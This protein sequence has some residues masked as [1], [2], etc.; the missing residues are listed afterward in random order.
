MKKIL[1]TGA[2]TGIGF[3]TAEQ[4]VKQGQHVILAC[5][6]PQKAQ[7]AQ[8]K[9]RALD[10]GQVDLI[11]LDLNS[12]ELIRKAADEIADRYGN[13]D[14]LINNAGLF[15]KTKQ[16]TI[17]GF[18]QQFGVNYLGHFL[19]TQKL[20]PVLQQSPQARIVHLASIAHWAGSIKPNKFRAEG[21][22]NPLFYYGQSK[23]ANL[24]LSNA[25]AE[26]L[27]GSS[28]TNNALH[29]GGVASDIY[30]D[31]PKPVYAAM[32]LGLVAT[33]VP[34]N[35]ITQMAIGDEWKNRNGEYV[36]AHMPVWKSSHAKNQ[37]LA[38]DLYQQSL[39]LVEKFL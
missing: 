29:P 19:L 5:R 18:E 33:S 16:L 22:Y 14:V 17:D 20:L 27:A 9:L 38:R 13:L 11:S 31:L 23:L 28:I 36:S 21:F 26:Q 7:A 32:K 25:L 15:A 30:R 8:N 10:Q 24:L 12:L 1:I 6:N 3:A 34:A 37:Q 39:A 4:L 2:N 35:L